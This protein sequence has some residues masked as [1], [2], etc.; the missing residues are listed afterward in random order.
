MAIDIQ[1]GT[2]VRVTIT[3]TVTRE[4]ARKTL[5]RVFMSDKAVAKPV[6]RRAANFKDRPKRRGGRIYTKRPNKP[7]LPL[8]RGHSATVR[9]TTQYLR[10]LRSVADF[11]EVAPA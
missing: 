7:H 9:A 4:A 11:V 3:Q 5:E 10:D 1:P 2:T 8:E 6:E